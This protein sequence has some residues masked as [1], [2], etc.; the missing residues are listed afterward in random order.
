M[1]KGG[2]SSGVAAAARGDPKG[3]KGAKDPVKPKARKPTAA[4]KDEAKLQ[5][6][7][8]AAKGN[9]TKG[10]YKAY[11]ELMK[12]VADRKAK[13]ELEM[14]PTFPDEAGAEPAKP[15][16]DAEMP[17][18]GAG[19]P[20]A[21]AEKP[22]AGAGKPSAGAE[23]S[24]AVAAPK[25][26]ERKLEPPKCR[27]DGTGDYDVFRRQAQVW[28]DKYAECSYTEKQLGAEL[29]EV[30]SGEAIGAVF[31]TVEPGMEAVSYVFD[32]LDA[33]FGK[34]AMPKATSAVEELASC[35]RGKMSL[36]QFLNKYTE[37]RAKAQR[38][39]E[40][41]CPNTSGTKLLKAAQLSAALHTQ[42]LATIASSGKPGA[43]V[44]NMPSY[45]AVL[46][47]LN[48]LAEVY[49]SQDAATKER[50]AFVAAQEEE[51]KGKGGWQSWDRGKAGGGYGAG[52]A[53]GGKGAGKAGGGKGSGKAG[54]GKAGGGKA[55]WQSGK[56]G[57]K[58]G[59]KGTASKGKGSGKGKQLGL[60]WY[61]E[62]GETCPYGDKCK[63]SHEVAGAAAAKRHMEEDGGGPKR[64]APRPGD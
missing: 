3:A 25:H 22:D 28:C 34:K 37:L 39:G 9:W 43:M 33:R 31:A 45:E 8:L 4:E 51:P 58:P 6:L 53:G 47:Q 38:A 1:V 54:G 36:R 18:A 30:L 20:S 62:K 19:K 26:T 7:H 41:M 56:H 29:L 15:S 24:G 23:K 27:Y 64:K 49:E 32:A 44:K 63:F 60:C 59:N 61:I 52:K 40:I 48:T 57:G 50:R 5:E 55:G 10:Q 21:G 11:A 12:K 14:E 16:A 42:V 35:T 2:K 46:E 17:S 13:A